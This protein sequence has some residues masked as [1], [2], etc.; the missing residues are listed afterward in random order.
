LKISFCRVDLP[1]T[2]SLIDLDNGTSSIFFLS[3]WATITVKTS[4]ALIGVSSMVMAGVK[5]VGETAAAGVGD[6]IVV[7]GIRAD[8]SEEEVS[9]AG[10]SASSSN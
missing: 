4:M 8:D 3:F 6:G 1:P 10:A 2:K 5:E 9:S 7:A